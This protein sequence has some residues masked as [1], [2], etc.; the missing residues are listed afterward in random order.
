MERAW[1]RVLG[2]QRP[3]CFPASFIVCVVGGFFQVPLDLGECKST[4]GTFVIARPTFQVYCH[5]TCHYPVRCWRKGCSMLLVILEVVTNICLRWSG[6][7]VSCKSET[8]A[9][10]NLQTFNTLLL[11]PPAFMFK[12]NLSIRRLCC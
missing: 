11:V 10:K 9:T 5:S 7:D 8:S 2:V 4:L 12:T 1:T 3:V 6:H